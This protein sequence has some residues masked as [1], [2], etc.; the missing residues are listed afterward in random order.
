MSLRDA[1]IS[2]GLVDH[3]AHGILPDRPTLDEFRGLFSESSDPR[4]WP[5]IATGLTYR[6]AIR[7][8][9][10]HFGTD[11]TEAAVYEYRQSRDA[12]ERI[13]LLLIYGKGEQANLS[14]ADLRR[15]KALMGQIEN[16]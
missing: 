2:V 5:H 15:V 11:A 13:H 8:L 10:A 9:A 1:L 14:A 16:D 6:R 7:E 4:Q 3:H 12:D